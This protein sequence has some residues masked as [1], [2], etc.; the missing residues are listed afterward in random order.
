M[1]NSPNWKR[2]AQVETVWNRIKGWVLDGEIEPDDDIVI[3]RTGGRRSSK[4]HNKYP[5]RLKDN[6]YCFMT[7]IAEYLP[8]CYDWCKN[9]EFDGVP[10]PDFDQFFEDSMYRGHIHRSSDN[11]AEWSRRRFFYNGSQFVGRSRWLYYY[12]ATYGEDIKSIFSEMGVRNQ[13]MNFLLWND[14]K[15]RVWESSEEDPEVD[16]DH[17]HMLTYDDG[18]VKWNLKDSD[19]KWTNDDYAFKLREENE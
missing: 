11:V 10:V 19:Y 1:H 7:G 16:G 15:I 13:R 5:L 6:T 4:I 18:H 14:G 3:Y 8:M 12:F 17:F 2:Y 9:R